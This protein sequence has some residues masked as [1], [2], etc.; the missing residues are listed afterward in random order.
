MGDGVLAYFGWPRA[1]EDDAERA[2]RAGIAI[3]AAV[4]RLEGGGAPLGCRV[5]IATGLVVVGDLVGQGAAQEE[6]V[7][8]ETP[9]LAARLQALAPPGQVVIAEAT[10]RLVGLGFELRNLGEHDMKGIAGPAGAFRVLGERA[11]LSRFE[12]RAGPALLPMVGRDQELALLLERW[13]QAEAGEGQGVLLVAEAGIG[14]SRISR[15][16]LDALADRPHTR[17]RYQCSPYRT[18]SALWPVIQ[19]LTHAAGSPPT[20]GPTP[21]W[22]S[23]RRC[24]PTP[25]PAMAPMPPH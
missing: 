4:A 11:A 16:L 17:I 9:N 10:R 12:A 13:A 6:A 20:T 8:G 24:S 3:T 14:K 23:W 21:S 15:A 25:R 19:Q 7:V 1:H 5:G 18:D 22:T 2:V